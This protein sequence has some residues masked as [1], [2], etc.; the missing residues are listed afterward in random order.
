MKAAKWITASRAKLPHQLR[1]RIALAQVQ[2]IQ[3]AR[4][5]IVLE[6]LGKVIDHGDVVPL[7]EEQANRVRPDVSGAARNENSA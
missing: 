3:P 4:R 2:L 5:H 1:Q 7:F 6:A